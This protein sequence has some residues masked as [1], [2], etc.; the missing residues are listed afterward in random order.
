MFECLCAL[1]LVILGKENTFSKVLLF[2]SY[3]TSQTISAVGIVNCMANRQIQERASQYDVYRVD[4]EAYTRYRLGAG[5]GQVLWAQP[6]IFASEGGF[7][8]LTAAS[9]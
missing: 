1:L 9:T 8:S 2:L 5:Q 7:I 3:I 4:T 6:H